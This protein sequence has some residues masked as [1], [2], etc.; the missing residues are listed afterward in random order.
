MTATIFLDWDGVLIP[1]VELHPP[2]PDD[3]KP[4]FEPRAV[5]YLNSIT[6]QTGAEIVVTSS[7][8]MLFSGLE[9]IAAVM[10]SR[11]VKGK[12]AGMLERTMSAAMT[13]NRPYEIQRYLV[14]HPEIDRFV[15]L[16]DTPIRAPS[17]RDHFIKC[18]PATGLLMRVA[19]RAVR[20]LQVP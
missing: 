12:V 15:I 10:A 20:M 3:R 19:N 6:I 2:L 17:L 5:K 4:V 13:R 8:R 16:D 18:N 1:A 11:G 14:S 9:E 7:W